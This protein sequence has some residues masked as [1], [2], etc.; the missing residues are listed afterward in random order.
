MQN[1]LPDVLEWYDGYNFA[2]HSMLCPWSVLKFLS[3]ALDTEHNPAVFKPENYWANS[4]GNDIIEICMKHPGEKDAERLQNLL[5]MG[6][7]YI[8]LCEF[9]SYPEITSATD[10]DTFATLMLHT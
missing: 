10:F 4:S 1:R 6:T 7:E 2:G 9:T 8:Q 3:R 5:N